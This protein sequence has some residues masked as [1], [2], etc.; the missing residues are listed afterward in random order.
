MLVSVGVIGAFPMAVRE[1][2]FTELQHLVTTFEG[3]PWNWAAHEQGERTPRKNEV[4]P[5]EQ[6]QGPVVHPAAPGAGGRGALRLHGG[7]AV[8]AH[9]PVRALAPGPRARGRAPT[10]SSNARCGSTSPTC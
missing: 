7:H 5:L 3:H 1:E 10:S 6:R 2:L 8:P 4:E 9:R